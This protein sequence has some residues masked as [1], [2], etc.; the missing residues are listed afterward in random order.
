MTLHRDSRNYLEIGV[1][2]GDGL[3]HLA[4]AAPHKSIFGVDPFVEDGFTA[5]TSGESQNDRMSQIEITANNNIKD[6]TNAVLFTMTS[7]EFADMLTDEMVEMMDIGHILI[8]GSHHYEDVRVDYELAMRLLN[9]R[10]GII[11]FDDVNLEGVKQAHDEFI[12]KYSAKIDKTIDIYTREPGH[13]FA[14][15]LNGHP[16]ANFYHSQTN[17]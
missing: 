17:P 1:F 10:P 11:V 7:Q 2:E 15:F 3:K 13:I 4:A 9:Q 12:N 5:H 16:D 8:D 14:H 6:S